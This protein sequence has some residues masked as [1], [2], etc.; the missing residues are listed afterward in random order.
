MQSICFFAMVKNLIFIVQSMEKSASSSNSLY[1][2]IR[3]L[4]K[5]DNL[6]APRS[7]IGIDILKISSEIYM[8]T[9]WI[10]NHFFLFW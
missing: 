2:G 5:D 7:L 10:Q 4:Q 9:G 6:F 3:K 1:Y 8:E